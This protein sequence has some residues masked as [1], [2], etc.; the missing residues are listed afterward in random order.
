MERVT[1]AQCANFGLAQ[2]RSAVRHA[3]PTQKEAYLYQA[4][5]PVSRQPRSWRWLRR[6][7]LALGSVPLMVCAGLQ[8][9][10]ASLDAIWQWSVGE[11]VL[12]AAYPSV[13][14]F[15][16]IGAAGI[17]LGAMIWLLWATF[18]FYPPG[19]R[20]SRRARELGLCVSLGGFAVSALAVVTSL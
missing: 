8:A 19:T 4:P 12:G 9:L 18:A 1:V 11:S 20:P 6:C 16:V 15:T 2:P 7:C 3:A 13:A 5:P 17:S 10:I 14:M